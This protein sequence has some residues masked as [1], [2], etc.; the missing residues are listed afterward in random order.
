MLTVNE[1]PRNSLIIKIIE[2]QRS[3]KCPEHDKSVEFFCLNCEAG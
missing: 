1:L 3:K 2:R